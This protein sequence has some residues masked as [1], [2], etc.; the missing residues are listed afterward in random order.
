MSNCDHERCIR[1]NCEKCCYCSADLKPHEG[2]GSELER[3]FGEFQKAMEEND[4]SKASIAMNAIWVLFQVFA[5]S[6][7]SDLKELTYLKTP[8]SFDNGGKYLLTLIHVDGP[9][10]QLQGGSGQAYTKKFEE[11]K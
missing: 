6:A 1:D 8:F 2:F 10:I 7:T 4:I 11:V 9:K 5:T 3:M